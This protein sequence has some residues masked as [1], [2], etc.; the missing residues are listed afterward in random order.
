MKMTQLEYHIPDLSIEDLEQM[1]RTLDSR[2]SEKRNAA[3]L[4]AAMTLIHTAQA[5][6]YSISELI[7]F[8]KSDADV[9]VKYRHPDQPGLTWCGKGRRPLWINEAIDAGIELAKIRV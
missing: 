1:R 8:L 6:G 3:R 5:L 9:P 7:P 4:E 2:I